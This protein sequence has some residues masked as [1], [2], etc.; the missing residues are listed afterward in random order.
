MRWETPMMRTA[1][2][3]GSSEPA[4]FLAALRADHADYSRILS[5][6]SREVSRLGE[7]AEATLPLLQEAFQFITLYLDTSHHPREDVMYERLAA[8]SKRNARVLVALRHEHR[9]GTLIS[10]RIF[11]QIHELLR[12]STPG[13]LSKLE[14]DVDRFVDQSRDHIAREERL[15]YS[16]ATNVLSE[17]DWRAIEAAAPPSNPRISLAHGGGRSYPVLARYFS[18][19]A[20]PYLVPG[21]TGRLTE[22]LGL[23]EAVD[24]YGRFV[25]GAVEAAILAGR[26]SREAVDLALQS[27]RAVCTPRLPGT[28]AAALR[29]AFRLDVATLSR[30]AGEWR[31]QYAQEPIKKRPRRGLSKADKGRSRLCPFAA[32]G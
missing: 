15:M 28:Y 24:Q 4:T 26:Q 20:S 2:G 19:T 8:R 1:T 12:E 29:A 13:R 32:L 14:K 18:S 16:Q 17:R 23:D 22:A 9:I 6:L 21:E 3:A 25:G 5:L 11:S 10:R 7:A 27:A 31:E 30:W